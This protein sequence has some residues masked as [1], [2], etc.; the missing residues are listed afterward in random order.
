MS[1]Q[2]VP[3]RDGQVT[4]DTASAARNPANHETRSIAIDLADL[5]LPAE[6]SSLDEV[7]S[8]ASH[9]YE[10][11]VPYA[12]DGWEWVT[13]PSSREFQGWQY[14]DRGGVRTIT[15]A[16]LE[17]R[18]VD[19]REVPREARPTHGLSAYRTRQLTAN[20][21]TAEPGSKRWRAFRGRH[22]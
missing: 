16:R 12:D 8:A 21:W 5:D 11:F 2:S 19:P 22:G 10:R 20:P 1:M 6:M 15:G 17:C 14:G 18:R 3:G 4:A 9:I 13:H 7:A